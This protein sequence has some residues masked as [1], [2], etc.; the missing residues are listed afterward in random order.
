MIEH[1][2]KKAEE[3]HIEF[4]EWLRKQSMLDVLNFIGLEQL[5]QIWLA[6]RLARIKKEI[7]E[8]K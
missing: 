4:N 1:N 5:E 8:M 3:L 6:K 7:E 2:P